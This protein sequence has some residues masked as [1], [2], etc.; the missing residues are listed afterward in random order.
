[1][2]TVLPRLSNAR[3]AER[4]LQHLYPP[5]LRDAGVTGRTVVVLI[6]DREGKVEPGSVR[7]QETTHPGFAEAAIRAAEKMRFTPAR[8]NGRPVSV[9]IALPIGWQL[10][11]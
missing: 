1:V 10:Q 9:V 11:N 6:I 3:E 7:V 5:L 4:L 8:L 2:V